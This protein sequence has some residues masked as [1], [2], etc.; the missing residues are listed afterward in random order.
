MSR[1]QK[2]VQW[3]L[4][5]TKFENCSFKGTWQAK[6]KHQSVLGVGHTSPRTVEET[7]EGSKISE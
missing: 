4:I 7:V 3:H 5:H 1:G 2:G 6:N